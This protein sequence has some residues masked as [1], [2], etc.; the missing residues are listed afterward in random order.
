M[1]SGIYFPNSYQLV[2]VDIQEYGKRLGQRESINE[3]KLHY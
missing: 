2:E 3:D 1:D